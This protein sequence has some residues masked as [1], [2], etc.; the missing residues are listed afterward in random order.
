MLHSRLFTGEEGWYQ[1]GKDGQVERAWQALLW[2]LSSTVCSE[3]SCPGSVAHTDIMKL[4]HCSVFRQ[5]HMNHCK[6][7]ARRQPILW[8]SLASV[9]ASFTFLPMLSKPRIWK[10]CSLWMASAGFAL[11][12]TCLTRGYPQHGDFGL[13]IPVNLVIL[14]NWVV[15]V[16]CFCSVLVSVRAWKQCVFIWL[17]YLSVCLL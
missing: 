1:G 13:V 12:R 11:R 4:Q 6:H 8:L 17:F 15:V 10:P 16:L 3:E 2:G 7:F 9:V 14:A 5:L